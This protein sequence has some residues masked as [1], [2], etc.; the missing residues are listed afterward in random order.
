MSIWLMVLMDAL[1]SLK[2]NRSVNLKLSDKQHHI[3]GKLPV[4]SSLIFIV[5]VLS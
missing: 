3:F 5:T 1:C 4:Y 2:G